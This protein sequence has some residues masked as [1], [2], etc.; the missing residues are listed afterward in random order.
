MSFRYKASVKHKM[1]FF[2]NKHNLV[3]LSMWDDGDFTNTLSQLTFTKDQAKEF[4][5]ELQ[6]A[7]DE[8][9]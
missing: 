3:E 5:R 9:N 7:L 2:K 6:S 4:I 1:G 8:C